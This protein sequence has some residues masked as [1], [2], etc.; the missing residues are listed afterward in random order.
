MSSKLFLVTAAVGATGRETTRLLLSHGYRVRAFVRSSDERSDALRLLGAEVFVGDLRDFAS[1][2][3]AMEG[4]QGAYFC[5]TIAPGILDATAYFAQ[6]AVEAGV[7]SIVNMSQL[8]AVRE[9]TSVSALN[10]WI[11]ERVFDR[12]SVPVTHIRPGFFAECQPT[13]PSSAAQHSTAQH[14]TPHHPHGCGWVLLTGWVCGSGSCVCAGLVYFKAMIQSGTV[15]LPFTSGVHAPIAA[16]DQARVIAALLE[17]PAP[18]AGKVYPLCG[19]VLMTFEE[20]FRIAGE[21]LG[22]PITYRV[23]SL[24]EYGA[25]WSGFGCKPFF[26]Q[27]IVEVAKVHLQGGFS[28]FNHNVEDITGQ[29]PMTV[30]EFVEKN[31]AVLTSNAPD[32]PRHHE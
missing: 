1:V 26:V 11:S 15:S 22:T 27:H 32:K 8:S 25:M 16:D 4:V 18:H 21:V 5:Y 29:K 2:R 23:T 19:P 28:A 13:H 7:A 3:A 12:F 31:R 17:N 14:S 9:A 6:A 24:E 20:S 30:A 10:H